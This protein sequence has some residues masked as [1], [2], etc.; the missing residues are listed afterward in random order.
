MSDAG[1]TTSPRGL[2][3]GLALGVPVM[4]FGVRGI[5]LDARD[6]HPTELVRWLAGAAVVHD[7]GLLPVVGGLAW[8]LRRLTPATAWPVVRAGA[9]AV[10]TLALVAWPYAAGYGASPGNPT[11]LP[12]DYVLGPILAATAIAALTAVAAVAAVRRTRR[13]GTTPSTRSHG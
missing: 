5:L 1:G 12:R 9:I 3:V 4:L 2:V 8:A 13:S 11:L 7:L 6:T 10:G